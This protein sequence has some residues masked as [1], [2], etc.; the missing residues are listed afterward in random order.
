MVNNNKAPEVAGRESRLSAPAQT[1]LFLLAGILAGFLFTGKAFPVFLVLIPGFVILVLAGIHKVHPEDRSLFWKL[2]L[3]AFLIRL[4][5]IIFTYLFENP[6][7]KSDAL[8]YQ[9]LGSLIAG[10]WHEGLHYPVG[11]AN[12]GYYY[13]N[14]IV[15][16]L[17]GFYPD[18]LRVLNCFLAV[19]A[20]LNLYFISLKLGGR[21]AAMLSFTL[22]VYFPSFIVWSAL[23]LKEGCIIFLLTYIVR[24]AIEL[25]EKFHFGR[26][27][28]VIL[29]LA[30]LVTL[31]F[32]IGILFS[33]IFSLTF[34]I[35]AARHAWW[36]RLVYAAVVTIITGVLL[37]QMGYGFLGKKYLFSQ[38]L[39]TIEEQHKRGAYGSSAI[40]E[41]IDFSSPGSTLQYLPKGLFY[42]S[43]GP[44][45]W[46]SGSVLKVVSIPEML[47]LYFLYPYLFTGIVSLW[48]IRWRESFFLL[49]TIIIFTL[50]YTLGASNMGGIYRVRFQVLALAFIFISHGI[51]V[52]RETK[53]WERLV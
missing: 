36:Q 16:Y 52:R 46:E 17:A 6:F 14:A 45:P 27:G 20:G 4:L 53:E 47:L 24:Q 2:A 1:F 48:K 29:A 19:G 13:L 49:V 35:T 32:Y 7:M 22:A 25:M 51:T 8:H 28:L 34:F 42:F 37:S 43:F 44:F 38:N 12:Y 41:E 26:L 10:S 18:V 33:A 15:Y 21:K 30:A 11:K 9:S 40:A 31:R 23:N 50:I 39:K 5:F 3:G